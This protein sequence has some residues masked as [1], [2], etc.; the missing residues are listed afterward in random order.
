[1]GLLR[2]LPQ[3]HF[4]NLAGFGYVYHFL[5]VSVFFSSLEWSSSF[6]ELSGQNIQLW[7]LCAH[8][9]IKSINRTRLRIAP[10]LLLL[11]GG[12]GGG[13]G[14]PATHRVAYP[15][16]FYRP[17]CIDGRLALRAHRGHVDGLLPQSLVGVLSVLVLAIWHVCV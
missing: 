5:F 7:L 16:T 4:R 17:N 2:H 11:S 13:G 10:Q 9:V 8:A 12:F 15:T 1:M 14:V 3:Y 6:T